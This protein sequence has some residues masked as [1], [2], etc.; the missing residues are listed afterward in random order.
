MPNVSA[1][2]NIPYEPAL[3]VRVERRV[4]R[5]GDVALRSRVHVSERRLGQCNSREGRGRVPCLLVRCSRD[6]AP[7]FIQCAR[8]RR[9]LKFKESDSRHWDRRAALAVTA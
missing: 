5:R 6:E 7:S 1:V 8:G 9:S 2:R 3:K 4:A